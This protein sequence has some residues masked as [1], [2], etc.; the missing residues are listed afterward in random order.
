MNDLREIFGQGTHLTI[1]QM[2]M[3]AGLMFFITLI[4]LRLSGKRAFGMRMPFDNV[5]TILLGAILSRAVV[6]ASPFIA[7]VCGATVIVI[8]YRLCAW[9]SLYNDA[10]GT[11]IK[12]SSKILYENEKLNDKNMKN[13]MITEKDLMEGI[14]ENS[15]LESK[16]KAEK[17]YVERNGSISVV[18]KEK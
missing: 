11:L 2:C 16:E 14:R 5:I 13:A 18:K 8:L 1:L 12:G 3:R 6:G 7:T 9:I 15:N 10:F 17:V 4:L